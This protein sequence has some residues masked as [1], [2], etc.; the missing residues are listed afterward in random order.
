MH[1]F[2][3]LNPNSDVQFPAEQIAK[4]SRT[5]FCNL[6]PIHILKDG[7]VISKLAKYILGDLASKN[8]LCTQLWQH[9]IWTAKGPFE[10][11]EK[12]IPIWT[13]ETLVSHFF[14]TIYWLWV[15][16]ERILCH[17][18]VIKKY[19]RVGSDWDVY[20]CVIAIYA[21]CMCSILYTHTYTQMEIPRLLAKW[22]C[23]IHHNANTHDIISMS[24]SYFMESV[25]HPA[26]IPATWDPFY[27]P[28]LWYGISITMFHAYYQVLR[29]TFKRVMTV[30][31]NMWVNS[32]FKKHAK[33]VVVVGQKWCSFLKSQ[34][35]PHFFCGGK[36]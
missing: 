9:R 14:Y 25:F 31:C 13:K 1:A 23:Y 26:V 11:V 34:K 27:S 17:V 7:V 28:W 33:D 29:T 35:H 21:L 10:I 6:Y 19:R 3:I 2:S 4:K 24:S 30:N 8:W 16:S 36:L 22:P 20:S 12:L 5:T 32:V 15:S 18:F